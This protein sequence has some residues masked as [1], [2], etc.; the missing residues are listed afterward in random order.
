MSSTERFESESTEPKADKVV[1]KSDRFEETGDR[2]D[3]SDRGSNPASTITKFQSDS[4][5]SDPNNRR[6]RAGQGADVPKLELTTAKSGGGSEAPTSRGA[7]GTEPKRFE[8]E[9]IKTAGGG[10]QAGR[11]STEQVGKPSAGEVSKAAVMGS[12]GARVGSET[13]RAGGGS[14]R[15]GKVEAPATGK[16]T[17]EPA[18]KQTSVASRDGQQ[19]ADKSG[20][21]LGGGGT[22]ARND[23]AANPQVEKARTVGD[24]N[25]STAANPKAEQNPAKT[26]DQ[27]PSNKAFE[28]NP[29]TKGNLPELEI[30]QQ[31]NAK[32][33]QPQAATADRN[34]PELDQNA[35]AKLNDD[36]STKVSPDQITADSTKKAEVISATERKANEVQSTALA[37]HNE[38]LAK[39]A[40][41]QE[42]TVNTAKDQTA[43]IDLAAQI[44]NRTQLSVDGASKMLNEQ[45][46][47]PA[48]SLQRTSELESTEKGKKKNEMDQVHFPMHAGYSGSKNAETTSAVRENNQSVAAKE[49]QLARST[50]DVNAKLDLNKIQAL[51]T[52]AAER[53]QANAKAVTNDAAVRNEAI[54]KSDAQRTEARR[55]DEQRAIEPGK[56]ATKDGAVV[57]S[58]KD[59]LLTAKDFTVAGGKD[60]TIGGRIGQISVKGNEGANNSPSGDLIVRGGRIAGF[61]PISAQ[62]GDREGTIRSIN[63][64]TGRRYLTG[65]EI[66]L[67]IALAGIAKKRSDD[68]SAKAENCQKNNSEVEKKAEPLKK[69]DERK[70]TETESKELDIIKRF[71]GKELTV[72][73]MIAFTGVSKGKDVDYQQAVAANHLV[74]TQIERTL[75]STFRQE[76]TEA[77]QP[78]TSALPSNLPF[79]QISEVDSKNKKQKYDSL[80]LMQLL[81]TVSIAT[82]A[83]KKSEETE[84]EEEAEI[85]ENSNQN[86]S[87][88][89]ERATHKVVSGETLLSIAEKHFG[90][91]KLGWLIADLN[92]NK[93]KE[94]KVE[95][96][97][98]IEVMVGEKLAL[99]TAKE[100]RQF[101]ERKD[102][103]VPAT[104]LV[105]ILIEQSF[106]RAFIDD[107][108]SI[109]FGCQRGAV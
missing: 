92:A 13:G 76:K 34:K 14:E 3:F 68:V 26:L 97:R 49:N 35:K 62:A 107:Q 12:D 74:S 41:A 11:T 81:P 77:K 39:P 25:L 20:D 94:S 52:A 21:K 106:D 5:L 75:G 29:S 44:S 59:G 18:D 90:D 102:Y 89:D 58:G 46:T 53:T 78:Q 79:S 98:V 66:G 51:N 61:S 28:Q 8:S 9:A 50:V 84:G 54:A 72:S 108:L 33:D 93:I 1:A 16:Q 86:A 91:E 40:V 73:A 71:P 30:K 36:R 99:P 37:P 57:A 17:Q 43:R 15:G 32:A 100:I 95:N 27:N 31:P 6:G 64:E 24:P 65:A 88:Q 4:D 63:A 109:V 55:N 85:D 42:Q 10:G 82:R 101:H 105:T 48:I 19:P 87:L 45:K 56:V 60:L 83:R 23:A 96:R 103:N 104:H 38:K 69:L 47:L 7:A 22:L 2:K 80:D 70:L 67:L